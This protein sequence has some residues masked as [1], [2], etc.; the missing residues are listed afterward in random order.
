MTG[1]ITAEAPH[2]VVDLGCGPGNLTRSLAGRWPG[3]HVRGLDA[4]VEMVAAA[5]ERQQA[6]NLEFGQG[7]ATTWMPEPGTDVVVSNAM[8]QWIPGHRELIGRWLGALAPGAWF[9]AQVPG[10]F[11]SASHT[12]MRTLADSPR[13]AP[14]LAGVLPHGDAVG[15]PAE[16]LG[17]LLDAG[18]ESDV[19]ET[20]YSQVLAGPDPVLDWVRGTA[21]RP[22]LERLGPSA[23]AE[24]EAEYSRLAVEA[25]PPFPGPDGKQLT[26]FPFRRIFM[27]GR[28]K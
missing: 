15:G 4:S 6:P 19:W 7:D 24:F 20:T 27:V 22:V 16:Y 13:W 9:A 17:L 23:A 18:F 26:L 3:A 12:I 8:L 21:L 11:G 10:N 2:L 14:L 28:K 1:R 25:Y 5:G